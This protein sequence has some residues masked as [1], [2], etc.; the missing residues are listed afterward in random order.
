M[1][2]PFRPDSLYVRIR[3]YFSKPRGVHEENN[4]GNMA[5]IHSTTVCLPPVSQRPNSEPDVLTVEVAMSH[6]QTHTHPV[7]LL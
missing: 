3:R 2:A 1:L 4:F 7:A 6:S 5:C